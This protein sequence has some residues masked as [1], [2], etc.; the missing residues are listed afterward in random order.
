[1][2]ATPTINNVCFRTKHLPQPWLMQTYESVNG[3]SVWRRILKEKIAAETILELFREQDFSDEACSIYHKRWWNAFG[4]DFPISSLFGKIVSKFPL[5]MDAVPV[6]S[7]SKGGKLGSQF[8]ADFG[9]VMTG[10]KPKTLLFRPS[11]AFP[12]FTASVSQIIKQFTLAF[13]NT[14]LATKRDIPDQ[15]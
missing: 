2:T 6:A 8:F 9:A 7:A 3:Y 10:A 12:L 13:S 5:L 4:Y 14:F 15:V 11:V 1:M